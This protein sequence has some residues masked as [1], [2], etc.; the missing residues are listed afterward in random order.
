MGTLTTATSNFNNTVVNAVQARILEE[1][2]ANLV[3]APQAGGATRPVFWE[4]GRNSTGV[5]VSYVDLAVATTALTEGTAPTDNALAISTE[6]FS[7]TQVGNTVAL[8]D[9][10]MIESPQD[11]VG[12]AAEKLARN[13][14]ETLDRMAAV[15]VHAGTNVI[16]SNGSARS[17]VA[18]AL[19][20]AKLQEIYSRMQMANI[21]PLT[22]GL[23]GLILHP[24]QWHDIRVE[25]SS[26][27]FTLNDVWKHTPAQAAGLVTNE[28]G[29]VAGFHVLVSTVA[30][31]FTTA[32]S[33]G[34]DVLSAVG[35]G[36]EFLAAGDLQTLNAYYVPA[37][38]DHSDPLAQKAILGWKASVGFK[39]IA[40]SGAN[41][42]RYLRCESTG[43]V[44]A[45]GQ[46]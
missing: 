29:V 46:V 5:L 26:V 38:G 17:A 45:S 23:Y 24:R 18:N 1:L 30:Q 43:T 13:A 37:G 36:Q 40:G 33:G 25:T 19:S 15:T 28:V 4:K 6:S 2:R 16:Y 42:V 39:L 9:L 11:L 22:D 3:H 34:K 27:G 7:A 10:A 12:T 35:F 8:S 44:L 32:G 21:P 14:A 31:T 41:T 20:Y